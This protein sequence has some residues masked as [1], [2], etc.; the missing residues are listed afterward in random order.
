MLKSAIYSQVFDECLEFIVLLK[1]TLVTFIPCPSYNNRKTS[2]EGAGDYVE[3]KR[4]EIK[5]GY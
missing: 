3:D 4:S 5:D 2:A 1:K